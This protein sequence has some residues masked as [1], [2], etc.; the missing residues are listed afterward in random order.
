MTD[1]TDDITS[2]D[3]DTIWPKKFHA[4]WAGSFGIRIC[5]VTSGLLKDAAKSASDM[6]ELVLAPVGSAKESSLADDPSPLNPA[7]G[8]TAISEGDGSGAVI[9]VVSIRGRFTAGSME[10]SKPLSEFCIGGG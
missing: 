2:I 8:G 4:A 6:V 1:F 5:N 7:G 3:K 10:G 9:W